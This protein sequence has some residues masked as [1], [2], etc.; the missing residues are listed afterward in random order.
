MISM[1]KDFVAHG[2]FKSLSMGSRLHRVVLLVSR[3]PNQPPSSAPFKRHTKAAA[4]PMQLCS[5]ASY[6]LSH[7]DNKQTTTE[8][9]A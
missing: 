1:V 3:S 9:E 5:F 6:L 2:Y 7:Q 4:K 8:Q